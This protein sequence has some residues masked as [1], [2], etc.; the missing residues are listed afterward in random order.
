L[1]SETL[2][3]GHLKEALSTEGSLIILSGP[4]SCNISTI[5]EKTLALVPSGEGEMDILESVLTSRY[6]NSR[7]VGYEKRNM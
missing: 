1:V 4:G 3:S 7:S 6:V 5:T 2:N